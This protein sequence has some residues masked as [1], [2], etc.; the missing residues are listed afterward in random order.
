MI[1]AQVRIESN[2]ESNRKDTVKG[3]K[4][5]LLLTPC[6][7]PV[8]NKTR[9]HVLSALLRT[10]P[11]YRHGRWKYNLRVKTSV[12][13]SGP[14]TSRSELVETALRAFVAQS[15]R[16]EQDARDLETI[17]QRADSLDEE[18][19]DVLEYQVAW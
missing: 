9:G 7:I 18:A 16:T 4:R 1:V 11:S 15:V 14:G 5:V 6:L 3:A 19:L 17:N 10:N 8:Y 12:T 13:L 2:S